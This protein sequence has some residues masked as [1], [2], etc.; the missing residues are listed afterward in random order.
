M[1]E[2]DFL[3]HGHVLVLFFSQEGGVSLSV[4]VHMQTRASCVKMNVRTW[5]FAD[6]TSIHYR[7]R[8]MHMDAEVWSDYKHR[9][10]Y[11]E[12]FLCPVTAKGKKH[13]VTEKHK[14]QCWPCTWQL[15]KR[16]QRQSRNKITTVLIGVVP[17][18]LIVWCIVNIKLDLHHLKGVFVSSYCCNQIKLFTA[19]QG[20]SG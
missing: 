2:R 11:L 12:T 8:L 17:V 3:R 14:T 4:S 10:D 7:P 6:S 9:F 1:W 19:A 15:V 13:D 5:P 18:S 20:C 16:F